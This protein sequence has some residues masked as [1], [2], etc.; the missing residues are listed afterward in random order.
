MSSKNIERSK[1]I[2]KLLRDLGYCNRYRS[3]EFMNDIAKTFFPN[4][5]VSSANVKIKS[6]IFNILKARVLEEY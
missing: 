4:K 5:S 1:I 2:T 3:D 6:A